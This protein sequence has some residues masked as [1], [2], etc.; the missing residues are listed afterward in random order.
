MRTR[1]EDYRR[2]C[3]HWRD[4]LRSHEALIRRSWGDQF[5]ADYDRYLTTCVRAFEMHYQS[6]AQWSLRRI[7]N[8]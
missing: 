5:F 8:I 4:R 3:Q 1:R 7:D 6:L 2:T